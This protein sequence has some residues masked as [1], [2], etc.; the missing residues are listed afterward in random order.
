MN[1]MME[2][3]GNLIGKEVPQELE[4]LSKELE[5]CFGRAVLEDAKG[6]ILLVSVWAA[7]RARSAIRPADLRAL[8]RTLLKAA[9]TALKNLAH[10][11]DFVLASGRVHPERLRESLDAA[12]L[13]LSSMPEMP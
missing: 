2:M 5:D 13:V 10:E 3:L 4:E 9:A 11:V 8:D 1:R 12:N 7:R 6:G